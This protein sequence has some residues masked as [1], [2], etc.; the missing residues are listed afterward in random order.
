MTATGIPAL[1]A[2]VNPRPLLEFVSHTSALDE[3]PKTFTTVL[4]SRTVIL[5]EHNWP[6]CNDGPRLHSHESI[7]IQINAIWVAD[8]NLMFLG[9]VKPCPRVRNKLGPLRVVGN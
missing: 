8:N 6:Q 5:Q 1:T 3:G 9:C 4:L 7:N 2:V